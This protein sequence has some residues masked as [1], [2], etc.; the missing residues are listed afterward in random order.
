MQSS[1]PGRFFDSEDVSINQRMESHNAC[2][3][4]FTMGSLKKWGNWYKGAYGRKER[5]QKQ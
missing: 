3:L 4:L 1:A 5:L 2:N